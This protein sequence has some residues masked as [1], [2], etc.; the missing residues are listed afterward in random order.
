MNYLSVKEVA[1]LW[2][3]GTCM[4]SKYCIDNRIPGAKKENGK[5]LIPS[6]AVKPIDIRKTKL[7]KKQSL[8]LWKKRIRAIMQIKHSQK[9]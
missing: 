4:I 3:I 7:K 5:W 2:N 8:H 1:Q 6:D 9:L